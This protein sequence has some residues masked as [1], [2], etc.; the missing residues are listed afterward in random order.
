MVRADKA[1]AGVMS[2][3]RSLARACDEEIARLP[4]AAS[5]FTPQFAFRFF[6]NP[7]ALWREMGAGAVDVEIQ[8]RHGGL[9]GRAFAPLAGFR[10]PLERGGDPAG[11]SRFENVRFEIE[12]VALARHFGGP[13]AALL[14]GTAFAF[15]AR[16]F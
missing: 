12:G 9:K 7:F 10:G 6:Q 14:R 13:I 8:H 5:E 2:C 4:F 3:G 1:A 11:A 15:C 16:H